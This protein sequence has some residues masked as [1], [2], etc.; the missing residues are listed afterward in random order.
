V[1]RYKK[2]RLGKGTKTGTINRELAALSHL[3]TKAI[4]WQWIDKRPAMLKRLI[5]NRGRIVYL[6][7]EQAQRLI[8]TAMRDQN[9]HIYPFVVIGLETSMRKSEILSIRREHVDIQRRIIYIPKA[10]AG[11]REQPITAHLAGFL[12]S[13]LDVLPEGSPWLFPSLASHT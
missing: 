1:E 4:E 5:E 9:T 13:Y 6:T 8:S 10:K 12:Q 11:A 2:A 7:V 3:L